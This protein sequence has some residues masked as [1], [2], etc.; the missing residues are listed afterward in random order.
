MWNFDEI[1]RKAKTCQPC[2]GDDHQLSTRTTV[3]TDEQREGGLLNRVRYFP[4]LEVVT[5]ELRDMKWLGTI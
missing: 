2:L 5:V 4:F 3:T 1:E